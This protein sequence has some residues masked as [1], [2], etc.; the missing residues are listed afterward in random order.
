M[1]QKLTLKLDQLA[2]EQA[3][4]YAEQTQTSLSKMVES[5]F[6]QLSL[7]GSSEKKQISPRVNK[8]SGIAPIQKKQRVEKSYT[9]YLLNKYYKQ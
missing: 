2:I 5:Y 3:K 7:K 1:N 9:D 4:A 8:L 6:K